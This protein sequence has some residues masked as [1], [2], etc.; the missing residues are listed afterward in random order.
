ML[1][2]GRD[3]W[4]PQGT[5]LYYQDVFIDGLRGA[6]GA[7][8]ELEEMATTTVFATLSVIKSM[9]SGI[10]PTTMNRS[11]AETEGKEEQKEKEKKKS[12]TAA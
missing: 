12:T 6:C 11:N 8:E 10:Y 1:V 2:A 9:Q 7:V 4:L 5:A 3:V